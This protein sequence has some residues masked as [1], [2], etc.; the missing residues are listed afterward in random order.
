MR[1]KACE[2]KL[3]G[4]VAAGRIVFD[5]AS[6][7]LDG[8]SFATLD[9]LAEA[10]KACPDM[11][12]EVGGHTSAEGSAE[13]NQQLSVRRAQSVVAYL[14]KAGVDSTRLQPVGYGATRPIAPNDSGE[15]MAKNRRI[16]F[17]V[18]PK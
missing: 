6:A 18:R 2:D 15:N 1:A 13:G 11:R 8:T 17:S 10:T 14:V 5:F 3:A 9:T 4:L 16:E 7:E 12:I